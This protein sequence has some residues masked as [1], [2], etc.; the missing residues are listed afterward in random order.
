MSFNGK[1]SSFVEK[2]PVITMSA[3]TIAVVWWI[4]M[5]L[6]WNTQHLNDSSVLWNSYTWSQVN[7]W[8]LNN[9]I[10]TL[11]VSKV[12]EYTKAVKSKKLN[13]ITL[14]NWIECDRKKDIISVSWYLSFNC[15][16]T[17]IDVFKKSIAD[18]SYLKINKKADSYY[19]D[20]MRSMDIKVNSDN[21]NA[22]FEI[23]PIKQSINDTSFIATKEQQNLFLIK[24][25]FNL[26]KFNSSWSWSFV[27]NTEIDKVLRKNHPDLVV[28][29][30]NSNWMRFFAEWAKGFWISTDVPEYSPSNWLNQEQIWEIIYWDKSYQVTVFRDIKLLESIKWNDYNLKKYLEPNSIISVLLTNTEW[31]WVL[32]NWSL[33]HK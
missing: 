22:L 16:I 14:L 1:I 24:T 4:S 32:L 15:S 27:K 5:M 18:I 11:V 9:V 19:F 10:E 13:A 12:D 8:S 23:V 29:L 6:S 7:S 2:H 17:N 20:S 26:S 21:K 30:E 28:E 25:K 33:F 3:F 31:Y